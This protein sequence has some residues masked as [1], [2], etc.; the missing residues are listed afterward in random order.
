VRE[1]LGIGMDGPDHLADYER[2]EFSAAL[3]DARRERRG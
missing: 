3:A 2:V 1:Q